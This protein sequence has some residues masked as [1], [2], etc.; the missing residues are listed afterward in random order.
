MDA[1]EIPANEVKS[2][3]A[4]IKRVLKSLINSFKT[5]LD[6]M[7]EFETLKFESP[8]DA[9][10]TPEEVGGIDFN[11]ENLKMNLKKDGAG[12]QFAPVSDQAIQGMNINGFVPVI[13]NVVPAT[14]LP[15]LLG[16]K[17]EENTK[18]LA[19]SG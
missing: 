5:D 17:K 16:I 10:M 3:L 12:V 4:E 11:P 15:F 13:I 19:R 1:K 6:N 14:N 8:T 2:N 7:S 9:A 18:N